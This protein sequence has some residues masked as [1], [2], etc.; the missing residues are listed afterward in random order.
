MT[1]KDIVR[2][3]SGRA[4]HQ[5]S[6][7]VELLNAEHMSQALPNGAEPWPV[8]QLTHYGT[9]MLTWVRGK[10]GCY[11]VDMSTGHGSVSD[12]NGMNQAFK[13][14]DLPYY[15]SRRGGADIKEL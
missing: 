13:A 5:G 10:H 1:I 4:G 12:Q 3:G 6:W 7:R 15:Y 9:M 11:M 8:Y 14:L 2:R